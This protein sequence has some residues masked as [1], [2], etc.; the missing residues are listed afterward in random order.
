MRPAIGQPDHRS[1]DS[2]QH[3]AD[4]EH[5]AR[6]GQSGRNLGNRRGGRFASLARKISCHSFTVADAARLRFSAKRCR[7]FALMRGSCSR[8]VCRVM[9]S[10]D[11]QA[12]ASDLSLAVVR[13][14]RH[15]RGR[16]ADSLVSLTQLSALSTLYREGSMTPGLLAARE[17][18]QPPSMTRVIASL[19]ELGLVERTPHP[20][21]GRQII[22]RPT[23]AGR[24]LVDDETNAREAWMTDQLN[25]LPQS[26]IQVLRDAVAIMNS[27][28]ND[29]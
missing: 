29:D 6:V 25:V 24:S 9:M 14:T 2:P 7:R 3:S 28:V 23:D 12:L 17:R 15:L 8:I 27:I 19:S 20:T 22:V 11:V 5:R 13:L 16:R 26:Q 4:R 18:V 21:D 10:A 1:G